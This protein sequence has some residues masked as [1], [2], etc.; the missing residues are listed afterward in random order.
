MVCDAFETDWSEGH[1]PT[2]ES[3]L[4]ALPTDARRHLLEELL[5]L[6]IYYRR[7]AGE[8]ITE[9]MLQSRFPD[10]PDVVVQALE[11]QV[12]DGETVV[13]RKQ[14][15]AV[16]RPPPQVPGFEIHEE[17]GR[18]SFGVVYRAVDL[19]LEREVAVKFAHF[20][21]ASVERERFLREAR[22]AAKLSHRGIVAVHRV[23]ECADGPFIVMELIKGRTLKEA[24]SQQRLSHRQAATLTRQLAEILEHAHSHDVVHRDLKPSNVMLEDGEDLDDVVTRPRILDFGLARPSDSETLTMSGDVL[25]TPAYMSPEQVRGE[26]HTADARSD[27]Y[28]LGVMLYESLVGRAPFRGSVHEVL[29]LV[30][31]EEPKPIRHCDPTIPRDL[32][33]ICHVSLSKRP[34]DRYDSSA[35]LQADLDCWLQGRPIHAQSVSMAQRTI[36]AVQRYPVV[37][38][39]VACIVC[40]V[41][42]SATWQLSSSSRAAR[43][44]ADRAAEQWLRRSSS[45]LERDVRHIRSSSRTRN[46][47]R[48]R[49]L[50]DEL[51]T[52]RDRARAQ[53]VVI[54]QEPQY[55]ESLL[56]YAL[57]QGDVEEAALILRQLQ[58]HAPELRE[59]LTQR[60]DDAI[61]RVQPD[62]RALFFAANILDDHERLSAPLARAL[63]R[64]SNEERGA[65]LNQINEE[66]RPTLSEHLLAVV[67]DDDYAT[68]PRQLAAEVCAHLLLN[69]PR[70]LLE[71]FPE[72]PDVYKGSFVSAVPRQ[73]RQLI[74]LAEDDF[75]RRI[76]RAQRGEEA[77]QHAEEDHWRRA[78]GTAL[79]LLAAGEADLVWKTLRAL[80]DP[81]LRTYLMHL[82]PTIELPIARVLNELESSGEDA[83]RGFTLVIALGLHAPKSF[84][85]QERSRFI[86]FLHQ[87][88]EHHPDS[89]IHG[90]CCFAL[91]R[92]GQGAW[93]ESKYRELVDHDRAGFQWRI[94]CLGQCMIKIQLPTDIEPRRQYVEISAEEITWSQIHRFYPDMNSPFRL[95]EELPAHPVQGISLFDALT[96]CNRLTIEDGLGEEVQAAE[97]GKGK[98]LVDLVSTGYRLP[99]S[100][101]WFLMTRAG[102]KTERDF[103]TLLT[104]YEESHVHGFAE[105]KLRPT[106]LLIPNRLGFFDCLD[107]V[108][109]WTLD[110]VVRKDGQVQVGNEADRYRR[111]LGATP[112]FARGGSCRIGRNN[113]HVLSS[114]RVLAQSGRPDV[115]FRV[116]R[117]VTR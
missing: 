66:L 94:N 77:D 17:I 24:L 1:A 72:I 68:G 75:L 71:A 74:P 98:Y 33:T 18:G 21:E 41:M 102:A 13:D 80:E 70:R 10:F 23:D 117:T 34:S 100:D 19:E 93:L 109:E 28:S 27:V 26:G 29:R 112:L 40:L 53:L 81:R 8:E 43:K 63:L 2:T 84:S 31:T 42:G 106:G 62:F 105:R 115:G 51:P 9:Q 11:T 14:A 20:A 54:D 48:D 30:T 6:E 46:L 56:D 89:G 52:P 35:S 38:A 39:L 5:P 78:A 4:N 92:L 101:E 16:K 99:V 59:L 57:G 90:A 87:N 32:A 61:Q 91:R 83:D 55:V 44:E 103:G 50:R 79:L 58:L 36:R 108:K 104:R 12:A 111:G 107:N 86:R 73:A 3:Y 85:D 114:E 64:I 88:V 95:R 65:W 69:Q 37:S 82:I 25:G 116:T 76:E 113:C 7:E 49:L 60:A 97:T 96:F 47:L 22:T 110:E 45:E 15:V 67:V